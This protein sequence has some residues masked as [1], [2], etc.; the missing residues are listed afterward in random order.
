MNENIDRLLNQKQV[1]E[2][3]GMSEAWLEMSRFKGTGLPYI[4]MG[5][6]IRY[7]ESDIHKY[8]EEHTVPA[9]I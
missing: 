7:R 4:K 6:A 2:L 1:A 9:G 5:R 8:V 3:L